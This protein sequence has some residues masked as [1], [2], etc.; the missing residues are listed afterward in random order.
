M[1][2]RQMPGGNSLPLYEAFSLVMILSVVVS[3]RGVVLSI[4][5]SKTF[6]DCP[7]VL[8]RS[9]SDRSIID[10]ARFSS[11][12]A[13]YTPIEARFTRSNDPLYSS[14]LQSCAKQIVSHRPLLCST[15]P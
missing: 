10:K 13:R 11:P 14:A 3:E 5:D 1:F 9:R 8:T 4:E 2:S 6:Q 12:T 15:S 7:I